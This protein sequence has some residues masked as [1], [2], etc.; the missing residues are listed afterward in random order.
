MNEQN[1]GAEGISP[2]EMT[3]EQFMA[4]VFMNM[5]MQNTNM[6]AMFLGKVPHPQT[7]QPIKDL[8]S[9]QMFIDQLE[10]LNF[11]T[12]GNLSQQEKQL[13]QES[14]V[15]LRMAFV[16]ELRKA[17]IPVPDHL[18]QGAPPASEPEQAGPSP[19][20]APAPP[21]PAPAPVQAPAPA[22]EAQKPGAAEEES[23]KRFS[24]KY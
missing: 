9:A 21:S 10:M 12:R 3:P 24:K 1:E 11:K 5:V 19:A 17:G 13:L 14:L 22:P 6:A 15:S 18:T 4:A 23:R 2:E 20:P 8:E 16:E 7:G